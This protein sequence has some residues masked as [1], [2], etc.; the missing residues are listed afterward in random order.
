[1]ET[2]L[3]P[4][5]AH[6]EATFP[7]RATLARL[8]DLA[9]RF[10]AAALR[11]LTVVRAR[12][13]DARAGGDT[14]VW[15]AVEA[16]QVTGSFKVR[17][18]LVALDALRERASAGGAL[19]QV[20][21]ASAGNH[22]AGLA[23]AAKLLGIRA[24]VF[25]PTSTPR[26]KRDRIAAY[27]AEIRLGPTD[28]Y[29]DAE[30]AAL[31]HAAREGARYLSAYD[32]LDIVAGNGAS[33]GY[34]ITRALGRVPDAVLA[35]LGGG[36][37]ATGLA[38]ALADEAGEALGAVRRVWGAQSAACPAFARSLA[39]GTV[40]ERL[41]ADGDTL[42]DGL[43]GGISRAAFAR[44][45]SVAAGVNVVTEASIARAIAFAVR[46]LGL[47]IEG[48]AACALAPILE[49]LPLPLAGGDVVVVLTGRNI[50]RE[51]IDRALAI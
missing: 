35:P 14:R 36:G 39:E 2:V 41:V 32:D 16:M 48:S 45:A 5:V 50:D 20:V 37:L 22:G 3:A 42:A 4:R 7:D 24:T 1:M 19:P 47:V 6:P 13:L 40:Y 17:G 31:A 33:L 28:S 44:V 27:G 12:E 26:A 46:E 23:Y 10:P 8:R 25:V 18:A 9:A 34:E 49:G 15:L 11:P 38:C 21:S 51:R 29:D 43:E 30:A